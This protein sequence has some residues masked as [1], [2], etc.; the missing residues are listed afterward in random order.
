MEYLEGASQGMSDEDLLTS[1]SD[2]I[3]VFDGYISYLEGKAQ[4]IH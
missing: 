1:F 2:W 3:D 4:E